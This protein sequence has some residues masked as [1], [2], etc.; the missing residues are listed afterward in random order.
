M[1]SK[2]IL[3]D[4]G[5]VVFSSP[6][7]GIARFAERHNLSNT[8]LNRAIA[9][10]ETWRAAERG[11]LF[12]TKTWFISF[13]E[14]VTS[15]YIK[16]N[17]DGK[18][19]AKIDGED[20]FRSMMDAARETD[21]HIFPALKRL[22]RVADAKGF[23]IAALSNTTAPSRE[24]AKGRDARLEGLFDVFVA[25][26]DVGMRKPEERMF[27]FAVGKVG[28]LLGRDVEMH[29]VVFL[30]DIG[31]NLKAARKLGM[32][33][34]KVTLGKTEEAVKELEELLGVSLGDTGKL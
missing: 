9:A 21:P 2:V 22:R 6:F 18:G 32:R 23:V 30:D 31:S 29:E 19:N 25:S 7:R 13:G 11:E 10:S 16:A 33:T 1:P 14:E 5:G 15:L 26:A 28:E 17:E 20:L 3:F 8:S 27:R 34:I 24:G 4:L 12:I